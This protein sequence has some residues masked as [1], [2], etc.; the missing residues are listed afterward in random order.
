MWGDQWGGFYNHQAWRG[1]DPGWGSHDGKKWS[2]S[3]YIWKVQPSEFAGESEVSVSE[4]EETVVITELLD[5]SHW[6]VELMSSE[7]EKVAEGAYSGQRIKSSVWG[8]SYLRCLIVIQVETSHRQLAIWIWG[9]REESEQSYQLEKHQWNRWCLKPYDTLTSPG[10]WEE[11]RGCHVSWVQRM[12]VISKAEKERKDIL[13]INN[14]V[15]NVLKTK[16]F[17]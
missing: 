4:R 3:S 16:G 9:S 11:T 12:S 13:S 14:W 5:L 7:M 17:I 2:A 15:A 8:M 10:K 1:L 6:R